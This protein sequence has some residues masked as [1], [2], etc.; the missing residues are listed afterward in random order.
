MS[1]PQ[2]ATNPERSQRPPGLDALVVA[3]HPDD[4]ELGM[5]G[6]IVRLIGQGW[7][8]GIVDLT[9]G[10]PTPLGSRQRRAG[11]T[12]A[13]NA[14]LGNPWRQN[15]GLPN[16]SLEPTL[17]HRRAVAAI[18]RQVRPRLVFAPYWEDAHPD[19]T[20]ATKLV[21]DARFWSKLSKSDIPGE[22]FHPARI[23]YYF[24]V[25][26]RLVERPGVVIDISEQVDSKVAALRCYRS[27]LVENQPLDRPGVIDLVCDRTRY[28]GQLVGVR[29]AEPF[30]SR[31]PIGLKG[32]DH[33]LL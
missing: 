12:A 8:V 14:A 2:P 5:G 6:T 13:A 25:H 15:L 9:D 27:Q 26:L 29:H 21:E 31:E 3:P 28:W 33:L 11:E 19:H 17:L 23:L 30:A 7:K 10:E 18:L 22:P 32:L 1:T 4:A 16:R 24:S 20:A